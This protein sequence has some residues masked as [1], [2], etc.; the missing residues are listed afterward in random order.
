M[1]TLYDTP[2]NRVRV[3]RS[4]Y[5]IK[6]PFDTVL[7]CLQ[8]LKSGDM[9]E[10]DKIRLCVSLLVVHPPRAMAEKEKVLRA[11][12]AAIN[13]EPKKQDADKPPC[14]DFEQD[15]EYIRAAFW[16]QYGINLDEQRGRMSWQTFCGLLGGLTDATAFIRIV[17]IRAKEMP[18]PNKHNAEERR[19]LAEAKARFAL[20][21]KPGEAQGR[22]LRKFGAIAS[23]IA[24]M[25]QS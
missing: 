7:F 6:A 14:M 9:S 22:F 20:K 8:A 16:Q 12:L 18:P 25:S 3:G 11:V 23:K 19:A 24:T 1:R 17:Q 15:A 5:K 10:A 2:C 21:E 13:E 4:T